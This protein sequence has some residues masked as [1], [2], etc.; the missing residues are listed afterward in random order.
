MRSD[1]P[2]DQDLLNV[3]VIDDDE[4]ARK[5]LTDILLPRHQVFA[6]ASA[7]AGLELLPYQTFQVAFVDQ[8]LPGM[9]GMVLARFLRRNNPHMKIAM[10]T[11][12]HDARLERDGEAHGV[13]IIHKPFELRQILEVVEAYYEEASERHSQRLS[14]ANPDGELALAAY[15]EDLAACFGVPGV[16]ARIEEKLMQAVARS[17][18]EL[19]SVSRYNERDRVVAYAGLIA[20]R[21]LGVRTPKR[22]SGRTL[23]EEYDEIMRRHAREPAFGTPDEGQEG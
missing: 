4:D 7:E 21:V 18:A 16:P 22:E 17:L 15:F 1:P 20:L 5:L 10:V 8:T 2:S 3:L 14:Q 9:Q 6:V 11:G 23:F 12:V 13:A 19:R